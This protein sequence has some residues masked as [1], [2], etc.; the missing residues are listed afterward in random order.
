[1]DNSLLFY[2]SQLETHKT[3]VSALQKQLVL[4]S[5]LR[6][7]IFLIAGFSIYLAL[8]N[9]Q[10]AIVIGIIGLIIFLLLLSKYTNKKAKRASARSPL[11]VKRISRL[12]ARPIWRRWKAAGRPFS[13]RAIWRRSTTL[14][15]T[16]RPKAAGHRAQSGATHKHDV[17]CNTHVVG[18]CCSY[19]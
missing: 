6:L 13:N 3:E 9:W 7:S 15:F 4:Y 14:V 5:M 2:K 12:R 16:K 1:M 19:G 11:K 8:P 18:T 17:K 10:I